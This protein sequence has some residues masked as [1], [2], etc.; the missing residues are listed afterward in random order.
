M[1]VRGFLLM[2]AAVL[3]AVGLG[4]VVCAATSGP[5]DYRSFGI[6]AS[7]RF[8]D[9]AHRNAVAGRDGTVIAWTVV[10]R[11]ESDE[12][13]MI[14]IAAQV[15]QRAA[16]S[17]LAREMLAHHPRAILAGWTGYAPLA[18]SSSCGATKTTMRVDGYRAKES[19]LPIG[20]SPVLRPPCWG[21]LVV[22]SGSLELAASASGGKHGVE[23]FLESLCIVRIGR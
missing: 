15:N 23:A 13:T 6:E 12:L 11:H 21:S 1:R 16:V 14:S 3:V 10:T 20:A 5:P 17:T 2:T 19:M 18:T 7:V 22:R 9:A 4:V 8:P